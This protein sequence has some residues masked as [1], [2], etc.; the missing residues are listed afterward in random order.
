[1]AGDKANDTKTFSFDFV[2][3]LLAALSESGAT[4][5]AKHYQIMNKFDSSRTVSGYEH[6]FRPV[7]ARAKE[8]TEM[9]NKGELGVAPSTPG[10]KAKATSKTG[11][12][13]TAEKKSTGKRGASLLLHPSENLTNILTGR[14][15]KN[16]DEDEDESPTKKV[17]KEES[18]GVEGDGDGDGFD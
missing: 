9:I 1:M 11:T 12:P 18:A 15:T 2:A 13:G 10:K 16:G 3:C 5:G 8:I 6:L 7:K 14:K 4:V 17:K